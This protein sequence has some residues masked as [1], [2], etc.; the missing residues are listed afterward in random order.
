MSASDERCRRYVDAYVMRRHRRQR[1]AAKRCAAMR[2]LIRRAYDE[3]ALT[4]ESFTALRAMSDS[5]TRSA[6][7]P[8]MFIYDLS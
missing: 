2:L 4:L 6:M 1:R 3:M 5:A 8:M 7:A